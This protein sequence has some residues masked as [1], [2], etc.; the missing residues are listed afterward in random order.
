LNKEIVY[1]PQ[2]VSS[3]IYM[4]LILT[5][6]YTGVEWTVYALIILLVGMIAMAT[7]LMG[8]IL[9][10]FISGEK[11][12]R[13]EKETLLYLSFVINILQILSTYIIY[14]QGYI[15]LASMAVPILAAVFI[16]NIIRSIF[17]FAKEEN[18]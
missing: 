10:F 1:V 8:T 11:M 6:Q 13:G 12:D 9:G 3:F 5:F 4:G 18:K 17:Y 2:L 16:S 15:I 7:I 14:E